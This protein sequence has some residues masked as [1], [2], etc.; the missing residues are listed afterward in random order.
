MPLLH[1][2]K[3]LLCCTLQNISLVFNVEKTT[4]NVESLMLYSVYFV[5]ANDISTLGV[6]NYVS[7]MIKFYDIFI[8]FAKYYGLGSTDNLF[9]YLT[10][11][12]SLTPFLSA[13][14]IKIVLQIFYIFITNWKLINTFSSLSGWN[15]QYRHLQNKNDGA[16]REQDSK[17]LIIMKY[18]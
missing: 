8:M 5:F 13:S 18:I 11:D 7:D 16:L 10:C 17:L 3:A 6:H 4:N 15:R 9:L 2:G 14:S 12:A 1:P